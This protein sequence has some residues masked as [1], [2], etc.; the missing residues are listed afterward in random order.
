MTGTYGLW[1]SYAKGIFDISTNLYYQNGKAQSGKDVSAY[2]ATIEPG[3]KAGIFRIGIGADYI[4]GDNAE[5]DDYAKKERT[6]N[7]MYG[8]VFKYYGFMNYYSYMKASTANGGLADIYPNVRINFNK[9][10]N[11]LVMFHKFYLAN[12]VM[13]GEKLVDDKDLGGELDMMYT[14]KPMPELKVQAGFSYYF[15][16]TTLEQVKRV[17]GTDIQAPYWGW[18]MLTFT[19]RLFSSN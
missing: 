4:S 17:D 8:A 19:P 9:K 3:V 1:L 11:L 2:M 15:T 10:H 6:F 5:N 13:L 12:A 18:V 7:K 14:F 16:T